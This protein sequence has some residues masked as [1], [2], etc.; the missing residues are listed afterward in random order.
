LGDPMLRLMHPQ[1][2]A[3]DA[4]RE[5]EAGG[6]LRIKGHSDIAGQAVLELVCRRDCHKNPPP[7]RER[8]N[9]TDK[10]LAEYQPIYEQSLD[11]CF[12]RWGLNSPAGHFATELVVPADAR[13]P[14]HLRLAVANANAYGLGSTN[15]SVHPADAQRVSKPLSELR[16]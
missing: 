1:E 4:A 15:V 14:C 2:I 10:A 12:A 6:R 3:I 13:G 7:V 9:P 11:R 5:A 16:R 8:F